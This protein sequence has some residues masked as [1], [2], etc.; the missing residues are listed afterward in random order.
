MYI[1]TYEGMDKGTEGGCLTYYSA[2]PDEEDPARNHANTS[3]SKECTAADTAERDNAHTCTGTDKDA[4]TCNHTD[5][6]T[7]TEKNT[8]TLCVCVSV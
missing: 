3:V 4:D 1:N 7:R 5:I 2:P 6:G 8:C